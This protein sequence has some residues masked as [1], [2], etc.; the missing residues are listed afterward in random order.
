MLDRR[1]ALLA[2]VLFPCF[3]V[4]FASLG[5]GVRDA[6]VVKPNSELFERFTDE[7]TE[8]QGACNLGI[9]LRK[10]ASFLAESNLVN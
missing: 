2:W 1:H 6:G 8:C 10:R 4:A 3:L 7:G 9:G 5:G